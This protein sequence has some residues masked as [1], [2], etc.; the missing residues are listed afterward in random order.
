MDSLLMKLPAN[1]SWAT[2]L[3]PHAHVTRHRAALATDQRGGNTA[4]WETQGT[5]PAG[6]DWS[7]LIT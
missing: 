5:M 6:S 4:L 1:Q 2:T 3:H 7:R